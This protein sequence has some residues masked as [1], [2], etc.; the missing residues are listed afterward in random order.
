MYRTLL[1]W[2]SDRVN[3]IS[4]KLEFVLMSDEAR[5]RLEKELK[6][7]C[8]QRENYKKIFKG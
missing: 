2:I 3:E 5:E 4:Y 8:E 6:E 1:E 7:L